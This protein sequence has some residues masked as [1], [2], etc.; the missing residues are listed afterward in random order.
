MVFMKVREARLGWQWKPLRYSV[1]ESGRCRMELRAE[2][3]LDK[4]VATRKCSRTTGT[5]LTTS[6]ILHE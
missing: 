5:D 6:L 3:E 4:Q 2:V 1:S